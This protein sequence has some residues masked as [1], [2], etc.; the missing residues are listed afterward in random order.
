MKE[1][2]CMSDIESAF[3]PMTGI[4]TKDAF[5]TKAR[6]LLDDNPDIEYDFITSDVEHFRVINDM[7]G[8]EKGDEL[9]KYSAEMTQKECNELGGICGIY[10]ADVIMT[11][12]PHKE[13]LIHHIAQRTAKNLESGPIKPAPLVKFGVYHIVDRALPIS[14]MYDRSKLA[15]NS[16]SGSDINNFAFFEERQREEIIKERM[17][18]SG[19]DNAIKNG[20]IVIYLQPKYSLT[21]RKITGAEALT[22]WISP[23][24]EFISPADFIPVLEKRGRIFTLD[25]FVWE[26]ACKVIRAWIDNDLPIVPISVNV[27]RIDLEDPHFDSRFMALIDTYKIPAKYLILELTETAYTDLNEYQINFIESLRSRGFR[28]EMDDFGSGYSSLNMLKDFYID[29]LK[30]DLN[31]LTGIGENMRGEKILRLVID[32]AVDLDLGVVAEGVEEAYQADFLEEIGCETAQGYY[33]ARPMPLKEFEK[34]LTED[35]KRSSSH[36]E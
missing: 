2:R 7:Y 24:N 3:D 8:Y 15:L 5:Y 23:E 28:V 25:L 33:F 20:E 22:R 32:L 19:I 14:A 35:Y 13:G 36:I 34:L 29:D 30:I 1:V 26:Q 12:V 10:F 11:I 17:I 6:K 21:T 4:S 18:L 16:I 9:I 31:F 27:S